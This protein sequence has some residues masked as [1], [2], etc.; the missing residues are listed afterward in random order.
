MIQAMNTGHDGSMSTI[1]SNSTQE[2]MSRLENMIVMSGHELPP[3]AIKSYIIDAVDIVVQVS[4]MRD[5]TR[6]VIQISEIVGLDGDRIQV[7]DIF[8]FKQT[9]SS[10]TAVSG[11]YIYHGLSKELVEKF[12]DAGLTT[13][14]P[15]LEKKET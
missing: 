14:L 4:R 1:H 2:A 12:I 15:L 5:G 3:S 11:K 6:R 10:K 9:E 8:N 13:E 7:R